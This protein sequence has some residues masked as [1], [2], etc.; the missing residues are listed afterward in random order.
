MEI[1]YKLMETSRRK[2]S[3]FSVCALNLRAGCVLF[4]PPLSA[5]YIF[6]DNN[7]TMV[8]AI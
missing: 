6:L 3:D 1:I 2:L 8:S 5:L 4:V 7:L